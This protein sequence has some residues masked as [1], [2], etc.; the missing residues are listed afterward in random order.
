[1]RITAIASLAALLLSSDLSAASAAGETTFWLDQVDLKAI[2]QRR[3]VP[4][5]NLAVGG[6]KLI[7]DGKTYERGIGTRSISELVLDLH[8]EATRFSAVVGLDDSANDRKREGTV[9]FEVWVDDKQAADTGILKVGDAPKTFDVNLTGART[10]TLLLDDGGDTSNGDLANWANARIELASATSRRP[11]PYVAPPAP[12]PKIASTTSSK[13]AIHGPLVYGA[14]P[15]RPFLYRI[16]A[17]GAGTLRFAADSLP[18]GLRL[19]PATGIITGQLAKEGT[20][21]LQ[22]KVTNAEGSATRPFRIVAGQHKLA[23]TPPM[24]WNS[25]NVWGT[26]VD[27]AKVRA[28]ADWLV[29]SGLASYGYNHIVID[30][31]WT[32]G[33]DDKGELKPNEKFPD[34]KALADYIHSKGLKFGIYSSP[35]P[36]TCGDFQGSYQH[37]AQDAA[38]FARWGVDFLKYDWCSYDDVAQDRSLA[39]LKKPYRIMGNALAAQ[40]RDIVFNLCQYGYGDVW[41]WGGE[42]GG[43]MWRTTGDLLD[44]WANLDSVGFRQAGREK[45]VSPGRWNDTDMLVVGPVG[46]GPDLHPTRLTPDEQ[47]LHITLWAMQAAPLFIGADLSKLD[48]FTIALLTNDEVLDVN[49][50]VL[51]KAGGRVWSKDRTEIWSRPL[52]DGTI[53]VALFN[54][55]L[56]SHRIEARWSDLGLKGTQPVRNLWERRD[57]GNFDGGYAIE[58]PSHGAVMLKI[59]QAK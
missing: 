54:R 19:D 56:D 11:T 15:G 7:M 40:N 42:V 14:T 36:K 5:A 43:H 46:W 1:M 28:A 9:R 57:L 3:G 22:L 38:T 52:A 51:A 33:R 16:P 18:A 25:W 47:V 41:K 23:L 53:A 8:G 10:I 24:G 34:M 2:K 26:A 44:M 29:R 17:T 30:D 20:T 13:P 58:V 50:D 45:Y 4:L 37:E 21:D 32:S 27:D 59:G 48:P 12:M 55:G 49:L 39:E 31:A 35:G 6:G